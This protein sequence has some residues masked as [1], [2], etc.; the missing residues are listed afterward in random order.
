MDQSNI[1]TNMISLLDGFKNSQNSIRSWELLTDAEKK[2][3]LKGIDDA[4]NSKTISS[5]TF[6]KTLNNA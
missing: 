6:W 3:I 2:I 5:D 4:E 1:S